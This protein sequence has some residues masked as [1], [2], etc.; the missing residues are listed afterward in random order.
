M[1]NV[2]RLNLKDE[3]VFFIELPRPWQM[4]FDGAARCNG[5]GAGVVFVSPEGEVMPFAFNLK[6][7][8]SNNAAEYQALIFGLEMAINMKIPNLRIFGDS[9]LIINQILML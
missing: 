3:G 6:E 2:A 7:L 5:A 1:A 9:K 8:C 4:F